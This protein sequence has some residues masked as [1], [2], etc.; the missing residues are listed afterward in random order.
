[1]QASTTFLS[2]CQPNCNFEMPN[3]FLH[4]KHHNFVPEWPQKLIFGAQTPHHRQSSMWHAWFDHSAANWR[5]V[6]PIA[7]NTPLSD[8]VKCNESN[9]HNFANIWNWEHSLGGNCSLSNQLSVAAPFWMTEPHIGD[10]WQSEVFLHKTLRNGCEG[11]H[12]SCSSFANFWNQKL[13]QGGKSFF[14]EPAFR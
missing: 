5:S 7:F 4:M 10:P 8:E 12:Q 6:S 13:I 11:V 9:C 3:H 14:I 1:M 2:A